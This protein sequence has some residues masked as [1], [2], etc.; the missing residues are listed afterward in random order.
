MTSSA[1]ACERVSSATRGTDGD[2]GGQA[3]RAARRAPQRLGHRLRLDVHGHL[4]GDDS[5]PDAHLPGGNA[6]RERRPRRP[7][8]R[9]GG[10]QRLDHQGVLRLAERPPRQTQTPG[11]HR[12]WARRPVQAD[13]SLGRH[14][15]RGAGRPVRR[16]DRQGTARRAPRR[17][18]RRH[19]RAG[20][21]R[22]GLRPASGPGHH[23]RL[24]RPLD[25][26][27][28]D[29]AAGRKHSRRLRLG[30]HSRRDR[31]HPDD[32]RGRGTEALPRYEGGQSSGPLDGGSPD[33][34]S[35][36]GRRGRRSGLHPGSV[37][38]SVPG[39]ARPGCRSCRHAHP[40]GAG[41]YER[42][43]R[44]RSRSGRRAFRPDEPTPAARPRPGRAGG[45]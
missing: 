5:Q 28:P 37:Q 38:R 26:D 4:F 18:G 19:H 45:R 22:R 27:R 16:P 8:R 30:H 12:L 29:A 36:L 21:A 2:V 1:S 31:R 9:R 42:R 40:L 10:G 32:L 3:W 7:D 39:P 14:A 43:L 24:S 34:A 17:P 15:G 41:D 33:G 25:R 44:R 20:R 35:I 13:L 23:R 11:R 6:G